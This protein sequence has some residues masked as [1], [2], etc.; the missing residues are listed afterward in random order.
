MSGWTSI[1][2]SPV[3]IHQVGTVPNGMVWSSDEPQPRVR[4]DLRASPGVAYSYTPST[5][6]TQAN[7]TAIIIHPHHPT[8]R[9]AGVG[10]GKVP[11][12][13]SSGA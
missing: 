4:E 11:S 2:I 8:V 10:V 12:R 6:R 9:I 1:G 7:P 13:D 3:D 5:P